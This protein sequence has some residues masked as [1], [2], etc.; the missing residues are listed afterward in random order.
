MSKTLAKMRP[1]AERNRELS[2]MKLTTK[3]RDFVKHLAMGET[4]NTASLRAGYEIAITGYQTLKLPHVRAA[5]EEEKRKFEEASQMTRAKVMT[6]FAESYE[7]AKL[8]AD[9]HAMVS[10]TKEAAKML[11]YYEPVRKYVS[12]SVNGQGRSAELAV[13]SNEELTKLVNDAPS[14]EFRHDLRDVIEDAVVRDEE[15]AD[16]D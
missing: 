4:V 8:I 6:Q 2:G 11:G 14:E 13:M 16:D 15:T 5:Y 7:M 12:I 10:A 9:P 1:V 3:Q